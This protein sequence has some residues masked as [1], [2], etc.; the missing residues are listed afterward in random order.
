MKRDLSQSH[1]I[2]TDLCVSFVPAIAAES[3]KWKLVLYP[4]VCDLVGGSEI[5]SRKLKAKKLPSCKMTMFVP[6]TSSETGKETC[7]E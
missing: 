2:K 5:H 7:G 6:F 3:L 1:D 4:A